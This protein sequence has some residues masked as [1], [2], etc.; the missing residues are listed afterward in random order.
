[1]KQWVSATAPGVCAFDRAHT[2]KTGE[3]IYRLQ[4]A[5]VNRPFNFCPE[6]AVSRHGAKPDTGDVTEVVSRPAFAPLR[7]LANA[8]GER[9]DV[10]A[11]AAGKDA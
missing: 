2:W 7:A 8:A 6:C 10:R 3:R 4:L 5:D 1:V 9:F 11:A